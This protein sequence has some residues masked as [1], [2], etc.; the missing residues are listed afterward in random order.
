M[1]QLDFGPNPFGVPERRIGRAFLGRLAFGP[2]PFGVLRRRIGL[3]FLGQPAFRPSPFGALGLG[4]LT[5]G[6]EHG[7]MVPTNIIYSFTIS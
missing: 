4:R 2:S 7:L 1:D 3:A 6:T 5:R